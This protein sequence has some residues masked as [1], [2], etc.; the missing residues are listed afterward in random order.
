MDAMLSAYLES[1]HSLLHGCE[2]VDNR[3]GHRK[4]EF[5]LVKKSMRSRRFIITTGLATSVVPGSALHRN[6]VLTT[7]AREPLAPLGFYQ[8]GMTLILCLKCFHE[9]AEIFVP[10]H[11]Q[12]DCFGNN[13]N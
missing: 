5:Q 13:T 3:K 8:V 12:L 11:C 9:G 1:G 4:R 2:L 10:F 6:R 7:S